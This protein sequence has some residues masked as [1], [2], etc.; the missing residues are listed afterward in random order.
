[1]T[2]AILAA[3]ALLFA[4]GPA[5]ADRRPQ[6]PYEGQVADKIAKLGDDAPQIRAGAAES[7]GF[8]RAYSAEAALIRRL[9]DPAHEVRR[10]AAMA[11]ALCGG[12]DKAM[13]YRAGKKVATVPADQAV[14][15][16]LEQLRRLLAER[17]EH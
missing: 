7:L 13:I 4:T 17:R 16:L 11:L 8:L 9:R 1:M 5:V 6:R 14:E 12:R 15:A 3:V 2:R 10:Q